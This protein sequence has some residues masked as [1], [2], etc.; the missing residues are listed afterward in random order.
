MKEKSI[1]KEIK[2]K[3]KKAKFEYHLLDAFIAGIMLTGTEIKSIRQGK[4][5]IKEAFCYIRNSEVFIKNMHV[6]EYAAGSY[7]NHEPKRTRKL[8]L[9]KSEISK[10]DKKLK[11]KGFSLVPVTLFIN[12]NGLAKLE[13]ALGQGKKLFDKRDSLKEKDLK[14]QI[15]R[16]ANY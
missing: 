11:V 3:N 9:N 13:I 6:N 2:I 14:R 1:Q 5:S 12:S 10:L 4:A 7:N 8:L 16:S 15:D